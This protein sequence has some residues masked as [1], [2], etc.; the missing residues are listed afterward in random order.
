MTFKIFKNNDGK[1]TEIEKI[2][3]K[4]PWDYEKEI[5][6]LVQNNVE[7]IFPEL[8]FV[9]DEFTVVTDVDKLRP[10]SIC[11][12]KE[13]KCFEIIEYKKLKHGGVIDQAMAYLDLLDENKDKFISLYHRKKKELLDSNDINWEET[14][15]KIISPDFTPHQ[16]RAAKRTTEPIEFWLI[17]KYH[18]HTTLQMLHEQ[19]K[20]AYQ[21]TE[22]Q[23]ITPSGEYTEEDY[24]AGKYYPRHKSAIP[25]EEG[26]KL[27][28][29]M[30]NKIL[31]RYP[32]LEVKQRSKYA[33]FYSTKDGSSLCSITV[34]KSYLDFG[35]A[36]SQKG[37]LPES[38]F[39]R[40]MV[41]ENGE[42]LGFWGLGSYLSRIKN[43]SDIEKTIQLLQKVYD[44]KM[45]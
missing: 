21:K 24:L 19:K 12:N 41:K 31:E 8:E 5:Q 1:L 16:L 23:Y 4:E 45:K 27:F 33:G 35:Y 11:F 15:V 13:A 32:D 39:V 3:K 30:K 6:T 34:N 43:E 25:T 14:K 44:I 38:D 28:K 20:Q 10:D 26:I 17:G 2:D 7:V 42:K 9:D 37:V 18:G 29:M 22:R 36:T 40:H